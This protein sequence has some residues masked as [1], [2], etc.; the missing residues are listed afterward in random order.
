MN[1]MLKQR[2]HFLLFSLSVVLVGLNLRP[3]IAAVG[4]I[5]DIIQNQTGI[6]HTAAGLLTA[7][8][9]FAMGV[10]ALLGGIMQR[11]LGME[12][13]ILLGLIAIGLATVA[14]I[15]FFAP[16]GLIVTACIGGIGIAVIQAV[17]PGL[18]KRDHSDYAGR[19]MTLYT[20]GIMAGAMVS[21]AAIS[22]MSQVMSWPT[23]LSVWAVFALIAILAWIATP[24]G[25]NSEKDSNRLP[26]PL[27]SGRAWYLMLFFGIGTSA[28]TLVLAWLSPFF[29]QLGWSG[30]TAGFLLG[31][32]TLLEVIAAIG[33]SSVVDRF[34]DRRPLLLL[35]LLMIG[36]GLMALLLAPKTLAFV[37]ILLLGLGI[38]ALF[39]MSLVITFDHLQHPSQAGSLMGFVQGGGYIIAALM[40]FLAG[41]L[42]NE[43]HSF[44][45]AWII[46]I[47]AIIIQSL[48]VLRISPKQTLSPIDWKL[49]TKQS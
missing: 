38:G 10:F 49:E 12:K 25:K 1:T 45:I 47:I 42:R 6:S 26:L 8:P 19:L 7:L 41:V 43:F 48:M 39:P 29:V 5:L 46:M 20:A 35:I 11:R 24:T 18:I 34:I 30:T 40:P 15:V 9:V 16:S 37:A 28:Y 3:I 44:S 17:L 23:A 14:R 13:T 31:A 33:L 36:L 2:R 27:K 32:L 21:S 4:P 22:P